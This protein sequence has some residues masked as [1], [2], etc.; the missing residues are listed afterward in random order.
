MKKIS[1]IN[2]GG[3]FSSKE[4]KYGLAPKIDAT[5]LSSLLGTEDDVNL[6]LEDYCSLDS[7]NITPKD[8]KAIAQR[9]DEWKDDCD[10]IIII[11]GT[12]TMAYTS[13]MLSFM[14]QNIQIPVVLTGSQ[15]PIG[16]PMSDA[17]DNFHCAL[18]MVLEGHPGVY[19]AFN[20]KIMLGCRVS[21]VRTVSFDAFESINYPCIGKIDAFGIHIKK[22]YIPEMKAEYR[23]RNNYSDRIAVLKIFPGMPADIFTF[24]LE[25][26]YDGAYIEGFGLGGVPFMHNDLTKEI[27]KASEHGLPILVGSQCRYEGSNLE[28]YETGQRVLQCGG[29]PVHDM[30]QEAVVTKLM[31]A[32][33]QSKERGKI[34]E[35]FQRNVIG[36]V[37]LEV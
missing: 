29:I 2:T 32:L 35:L 7:S 33:G 20:R 3:T 26:G 23:L 14:L 8:W 5:E 24:L 28:I 11:H 21:K 31:W 9:V 12:D 30:T 37:T 17:V 25:N 27:Q 4:T 13:S 15:L 1:V 22:H 16:M 10:G 36:E 6:V 19:L 34:I 18:K